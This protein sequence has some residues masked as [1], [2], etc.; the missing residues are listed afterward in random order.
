MGVGMLQRVD[1]LRKEN[2]GLKSDLKAPQFIAAELQCQVVE[3]ECKLQE[4]KGASLGE[5]DGRFGR[6]E[7]GASR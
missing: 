2:E 4:E 6:R 5:G 7:G 1:D 3:A